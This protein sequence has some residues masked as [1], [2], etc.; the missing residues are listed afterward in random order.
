MQKTRYLMESKSLGTDPRVL[1]IVL[2]VMENFAIKV[3]VGVISGLLANA[4]E[5]ALR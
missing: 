1:G 5:F 3:F 4:I 2:A